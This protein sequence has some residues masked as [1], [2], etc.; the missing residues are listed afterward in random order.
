MVGPTVHVQTLEPIERNVLK[1]MEDR[2]QGMADFLFPRKETHVSI[3]FS[4]GE[5]PEKSEKKLPRP[6][7]TSG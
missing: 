7:Q 2:A 5:C 1:I 6:F 4:P 3:R